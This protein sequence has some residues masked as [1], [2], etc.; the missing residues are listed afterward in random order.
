MDKWI[1]FSH[2]NGLT[3]NGPGQIDGRG[4]SWWSHE[5]Q[6]PTALQFN[7]CNG[8]RLNGLH[9]VNSP[10]NHISIESCSYA[11]LYQ[12]QIN[13]PKDSPNT[14]GIDISNSTHVR[15]INST[16]ST[17]DD[18]IAIN[19]GSSYINISYV[20]CGP[21]HGISIG[22]LGELGSYATVEEIHVQY[23]NFFGTETG[24]RIKTW[25]GGS[26]YAR[27]I[28]F[29]EITVT[30][31]DIPIII[32]QYYCPSGNCPNKTSAVE[33]S[34]VTYNGIRG[35]STKEDVISLCCSETVACR[36]IVMNFVNL[37]STAPG[38]EAR[39][40]CLNAHGRSIHTN[41][42]V[43]CLVSNYAIA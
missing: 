30:E 41:P 2:V 24:A 31:V 43:H 37:T 14:D 32:D 39:S 11:T 5:C 12:L 7:A 28:F 9:H 13:S 42:P 23:C 4:S 17:G 21:G 18:C 40:Y 8:L 16:I 35:S 1:A 20:N 25:Q 27:R 22:S 10:R 34:D 38:K 26:G 19:S 29:F 36:N 3:I 6:R 33:V 15:I